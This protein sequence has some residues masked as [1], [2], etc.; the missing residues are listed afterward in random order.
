MLVLTQGDTMT[1]TRTT[2][3][4][5]HTAPTSDV[6]G[7]E[8][9]SGLAVCVDCLPASAVEPEPIRIT[10]VGVEGET[11]AGCGSELA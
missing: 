11:C 10:D 8:L 2:V 5:I 9:S 4:S 3:R 1:T 7:Y 6:V